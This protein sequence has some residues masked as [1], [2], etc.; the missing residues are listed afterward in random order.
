MAARHVNVVEELFVLSNRSATGDADALAELA[1]A[2][3]DD[4]SIESWLT[5]GPSTERGAG[6]VREYFG[7][8]QL[9][10]GVAVRTRLR[11]GLRR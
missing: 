4:A 5:G 3:H 2:Y 10:R 8:G 7:T 11:A 9:L 1:S 6:A